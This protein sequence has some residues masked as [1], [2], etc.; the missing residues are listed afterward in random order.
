[1]PHC[2]RQKG[3]LHSGEKKK[4]KNKKK[5]KRLFLFSSSSSSPRKTKD[6]RTLEVFLP[7]QH[8]GEPLRLCHVA[9]SGFVSCSSDALVVVSP[10]PEIFLA[11]FMMCPGYFI[12]R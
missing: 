2:H 6:K 4:N 7:R 12:S 9:C 1:M 3:Y 8:V 10:L 11:L 5:K